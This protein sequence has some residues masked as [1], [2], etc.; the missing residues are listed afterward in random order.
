M[1]GARI[2]HLNGSDLFMLIYDMLVVVHAV[3]SNFLPTEML[4]MYPNSYRLQLPLQVVSN[5]TLHVT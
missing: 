1:N 2:N 4:S 3:P 5:V